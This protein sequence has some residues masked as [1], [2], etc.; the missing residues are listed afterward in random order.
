ME[1]NLGPLT[2]SK[3]LKDANRNKF[4]KKRKKTGKIWNKSERM[5]LRV[6]KILGNGG[7]VF[8]K[9]TE[10][11]VGFQWV[12]ILPGVS[13]NLSRLPD[14]IW[15]L[16]IL[17]WGCSDEPSP[18]SSFESV[19]LSPPSLRCLVPW[20]LWINF[21]LWVSKS[22]LSSLSLFHFPNSRFIISHRRPNDLNVKPETQPKAGLVMHWDCV[23]F[24]MSLSCHKQLSSKLPTWTVS[25]GK[26]LCSN[27][28]VLKRSCT[29]LCLKFQ[30]STPYP[31]LNVHIT[32]KHIPC[33]KYTCLLI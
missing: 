23:C 28:A 14:I 11:K 15:A 7:C 24:H 32:C 9:Q 33:L 1:S 3:I 20:N 19:T 18:W 2:F 5:L 30:L 26:R 6:E 8:I 10:E 16:L 21:L 29:S 25:S 31:P 13:R 4:Q 27:V 22:S 17:V 12:C